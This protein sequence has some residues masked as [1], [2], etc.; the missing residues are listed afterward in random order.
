MHTALLFTG[1]ALVYAEARQ[2][3]P[4]ARAWL[5]CAGA[6]LCGGGAWS[7]AVSLGVGPGIASAVVLSM[8]A[9]SLLALVVPLAP[10]AGWTLVTATLAGL[11]LC[12]LGS[13]R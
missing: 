12:A 8:A 5:R 2:G 13:L 4:A 7:A 9:L 10:R 11:W 6:A 1:V 3:P